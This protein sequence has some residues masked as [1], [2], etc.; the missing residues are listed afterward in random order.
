MTYI[1]YNPSSGDAWEMKF[2]SFEQMDKWKDRNK[3]FTVLDEAKGYLP[4]RH[5]RMQSDEEF[6]GWGS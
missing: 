2:E 4:T 1:V 5:V 3:N 6:A